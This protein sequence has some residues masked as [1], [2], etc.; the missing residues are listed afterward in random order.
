LPK[1]ILPQGHNR[2]LY[3]KW[4]RNTV[5]NIFEN[6]L[7]PIYGNVPWNFTT[8][9]VFI[10]HRLDGG[11][12]DTFYLWDLDRTSITHFMLYIYRI[13][14]H[15]LGFSSLK[16][17]KGHGHQSKHDLLEKGM[18]AYWSIALVFVAITRSF[19]FVFWIYLQPF[20]C[21]TYF[22]AL[23]NIGFHGFIEI[24]SNGNNIR[25]VNSTCII[26]GDDDYYGE[27]DHMAHHYNIN[28]YYRD[29]PALQASKVCLPLTL[30]LPPPPPLRDS[31]PCR[32]QVEEFKKHHASVFQHLSILELSIFILFGLWDKLAD[33]Y[34]DYTEKMTREEIIK[35]LQVRAVRVETSY[36][37]YEN[38]LANPTPEARKALLPEIKI[39]EN[40][41][42]AAEIAA[43]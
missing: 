20:I 26:N 2:S 40:D 4:I 19:S 42:T 10:H 43:D 16:F 28:V 14:H 1:S 17:F 6:V 29:L 37:K 24:D 36:E 3:K 22:L 18:Y 27:D 7:G 39:V 34:V 5:G 12:G 41:P 30:A 33:H 23:L 21:M 32:L 38:Y 9:H 25:C 13:A 8:S 15:M 35:M 11:A 31:R